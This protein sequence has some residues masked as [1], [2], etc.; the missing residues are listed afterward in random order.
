VTYLSHNVS[1]HSKE[2]IAPSNRGIKQL[3]PTLFT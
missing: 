2:Q 1:F 3:D